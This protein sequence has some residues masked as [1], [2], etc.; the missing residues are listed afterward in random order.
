MSQKSVHILDQFLHELGAGKSPDL[1]SAARLLDENDRG[2]ILPIMIRHHALQRHQSGREPSLNDYQFASEWL[3]AERL[4]NLIQRAD[5]DVKAENETN[6][7]SAWDTSQL[8]R[9]GFVVSPSR[10]APIDSIS[11]TPPHRISK[12][13]IEHV[14]GHGS[15]GVVLK[16][17]DEAIHRV[18]A[19]KIPKDP[20]RP[21]EEFAGEARA[22]ASLYHTNIIPL[23]EFGTDKDLGVP[24]LVF[25]FVAG[26]D[27]SQLIEKTAPM[28]PATAVRL[29]IDIAGAIQYAH[30]AD[31]YHRDLKPKNVLIDNNGRPY[32]SDFGL[33]IHV[34]AQRKQR[35]EIAGTLAYMAPEQVR[36]ETG[37]LDGRSDVWG[38]GIILYEMLSKR[39]PFSGNSP[40]E[41][42]SGILNQYPRPLTQFIANVPSSLDEI[43]RRC[44]KRSPEDR[45]S[46]AGELQKALQGWL[47]EYERTST[48]AP[49]KPMPQPEL[50]PTPLESELPQSA[51]ATLP[52]REFSAEPSK[53]PAA[54][55]YR[56]AVGWWWPSVVGVL[57]VT[58]SAMAPFLAPKSEPRRLA[59][60]PNSSMSTEKGDA[61]ENRVHLTSEYRA[62]CQIGTG[63]TTSGF[64]LKGKVRNFGQGS[65]GFVWGWQQS[66]I[67]PA[68][69]T[70][71]SLIIRENTQTP[72]AD[73]YLDWSMLEYDTQRHYIRNSIGLGST[74][75]L[76]PADRWGA[77]IQF[78]VQGGRL[79]DILWKG[80]PIELLDGTV[81][82]VLTSKQNVGPIGFIVEDASAELKDVQI[83][84]LK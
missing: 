27:L 57:L 10:V 51:Q 50:P 52:P 74:P 75:S 42:R 1:E 2:D 40:E 73:F 81:G 72:T 64:T 21:H 80:R 47:R 22:N 68:I 63:E 14:I 46:S 56:F 53:T 83:V 36:G 20:N 11:W 37:L 13:V 67:D 62:V 41:I 24:Y 18:V 48:I 23:L 30:A 15:F 71:Q 3:S 43:C 78:T 59:W 38:L 39:R 12:F 17:I 25:P 29:I 66:P 31:L 54:K 76:L 77:S 45:F 61:T 16:G 70:C 44:L 8:T 60:G 26:G 58:V 6:L 5:T 32:V 79:K 28:D 84:Q 49:P 7:R 4:Q 34:T 69:M 33:S 55:S 19:I 82:H 65:Y 35:H 9:D